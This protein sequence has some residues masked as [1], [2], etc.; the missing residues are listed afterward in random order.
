MNKDIKFSVLMCK[1][2]YESSH[3]N[4]VKDA[5]VNLYG[6]EFYEVNSAQEI[7]NYINTGDKNNSKTI[8]EERRS[9]KVKQLFFYSHGLV[10]KIALG[11]G[12]TGDSS[13]YAFGEEEVLKLSKEA[14]SNDSHIYS[15]ACRTGL[16]N[17]DID[18]SIY[19]KQ[20][21]KS[22]LIGVTSVGVPLYNDEFETIQMPLYSAQ[23]IAQ[24]ISNQTNAT[25]YAYLRR[26]DYEE[27]LF[28]KDELCFSDYMKIREGN[29]SIKPNKERCGNKYDYL[30]SSDYKLIES[31]SKRWNEW[32]SIESNIK[33]ID[34]AFFDPDG[35]RHNVKAKT[36]TCWCSCRNANF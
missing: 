9:Y 21:K 32:K 2:G 10:G 7:I 26:S 5:V 17:P 34:D 24:K 19:K 29:K 30:L 1:K 35:A 15:F 13:E 28:T 11:M 3:I 18:K 14:F 4:A 22:E 33:K 16:G 36:I 27:T 20:I 23:S 12:L 6:G 8:S 31:E 25:V